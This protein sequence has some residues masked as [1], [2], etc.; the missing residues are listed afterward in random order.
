LW[1]QAQG[2]QLAGPKLRRSRATEETKY[3]EPNDKNAF[4]KVYRG[5]N[6]LAV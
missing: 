4:E 1:V 3:N 6:V 5:M 2:R